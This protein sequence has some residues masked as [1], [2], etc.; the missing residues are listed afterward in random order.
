MIRLEDNIV[1]RLDIGNLQDLATTSNRVDVT[2]VEQLGNNLPV[3]VLQFDLAPELQDVL[4]HEMVNVEMT[5]GFS[6]NTS[7]MSR[8][9]VAGFKKI[10]SSLVLTLTLNRDYITLS[11]AR[12]FPGKDSTS[13]IKEVASK[14]FGDVKLDGNFQEVSSFEVSNYND[15]MD[16]IQRETCD[17]Q[18]IDEVWLHSHKPNSLLVPGI[19]GNLYGSAEG[20]YGTFRLIDLYDRSNIIELKRDTE[21]GELDEEGQPLKN[22]V[23]L[24]DVMYG[25]NSALFNYQSGNTRLTQFDIDRSENVDTEVAVNPIFGGVYNIAKQAGSSDKL[26][27]RDCSA[28]TR[29]LS[30]NV[31]PKFHE[32]AK[33]NL[34]RLSKF[35]GANK[36]LYVADRRGIT[37]GDFIRVQSQIHGT[38]NIAPIESGDYVV[39]GMVTKIVN[40][41]VK[42]TYGKNLILRRDTI[43]VMEYDGLFKDLSL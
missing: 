17:R 31:H 22:L 32:A 34:N 37:I 42:R 6:E 41:Q 28:P 20:K 14:Y 3:A 38:K 26:S 12:V 13:V 30:D 7:V 5:V 40:N 18:F 27:V 29:F 2:I 24:D 10:K 25:S 4:S 16:W 36:L 15:K 43:D 19:L 11:R 8:W 9:Q 33:L 21:D 1:F 35:G 39:A 23:L